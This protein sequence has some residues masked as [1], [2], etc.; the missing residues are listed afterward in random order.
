[1]VDNT[2]S[3]RTVGGFS[4]TNPKVYIVSAWHVLTLLATLL[5]ISLVKRVSFAFA[6][7][8]FTLTRQVA[9]DVANIFDE[10]L[11]VCL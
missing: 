1:M 2:L 11:L 9:D 8:R 5:L 4:L 10:R 6:Y 3:H 7:G